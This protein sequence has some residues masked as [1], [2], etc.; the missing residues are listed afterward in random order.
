V[1][2]VTLNGKWIEL[3]RSGDYGEKGSYSNADI[4]KMVGR[5][6]ACFLQLGRI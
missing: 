6:E 5:C 4:D 3:F 1:A 2:V